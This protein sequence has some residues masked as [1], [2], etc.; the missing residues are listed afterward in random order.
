MRAV[1]LGLLLGLSCLAP[2]SAQEVSGL[3]LPGPPELTSPAS[4]ESFKT[5]DEILSEL[6]AILSESVDSSE[7]VKL[8]VTELQ[9]RLAESRTQVAAVSTS[10]ESSA[11]SLESSSRDLISL[12]RN[13]RLEVW[14]W[15]IVAGA[16]VIFAATR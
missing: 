16:A 9:S 2:L 3:P 11:K 13:Q 4:P 8:L 14:I 10:L 12:Y 7:K 1:L 6:E 5:L 15:R